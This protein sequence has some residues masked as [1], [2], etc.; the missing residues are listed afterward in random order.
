M[1]LGSRFCCCLWIVFWLLNRESSGLVNSCS[2]FAP[3]E[4]VDF[5]SSESHHDATTTDHLSV[6]NKKQRVFKGFF[7]GVRGLYNLVVL[8][9][10]RMRFDFFKR[11]HFKSENFRMASLRYH[12]MA[13]PWVHP[14]EM[15]HCK[16]VWNIGHLYMPNR[17]TWHGFL[18]PKKITFFNFIF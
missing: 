15:S 11:P 8:E 2:M 12:W 17:T 14:V 7:A 10:C 13:R 9:W 18:S 3:E 6:W 5:S 4:E 1:L 16:S